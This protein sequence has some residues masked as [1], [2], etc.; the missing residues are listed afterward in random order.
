MITSVN[1]DRE[2]GTIRSFVDTALLARDAK[3]FEI[4]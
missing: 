2:I 1:G 4:M 3:A